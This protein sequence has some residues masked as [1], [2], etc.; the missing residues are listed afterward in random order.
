[1]D[2]EPSS[3]RLALLASPLL[4]PAVWAPVAEVLRR[5]GW[6]V[7]A[8]TP[9]SAVTGPD[10]VVRHLLGEIP[11]GVPVVLVPHSN[12]GLYVA[13]L[14]AE[15]DV[16]GVVFVDAGLP[17]DRSTTP[18]A[19]ASFREFLAGLAD[20]RGVLPVW[21]EWWADEDLTGLFPDP[22]Q[23]AA[24][25][26]EQVRLPVAYFDAEVPSPVGWQDLPT[27]Y[28]AFG[29]TY[30]AERDDAERRGWAVATLAG[31]HLHPLVDPVGV[32]DAL[33]GLLGQMG[34]SET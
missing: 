13:A 9:Y 5:R 14:A 8:P 24:V 16:R 21:T 6:D 10:D 27:A 11:H 28:L 12:A 29:D 18:T 7:L 32:T 26:A 25:V 1:M 17:A 31:G 2:T 15:R 20:D 30:A 23:E 33:V 22:E 4:G 19:P 3:V 34:H